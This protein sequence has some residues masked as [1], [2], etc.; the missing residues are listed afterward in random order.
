[1]KFEDGQAR[2]LTEPIFESVHLWN[3]E[4][5]LYP[6]KQNGLY[7]FIDEN[8]QWVLEPEWDDTYGFEN[9]LAWVEK[10]CKAAYIDREGNVV[11]QE[12]RE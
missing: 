4:D 1:M 7:G 10:D 2:Y 3:G 12:T 11:W 5:G 8:G 6:A 9:G